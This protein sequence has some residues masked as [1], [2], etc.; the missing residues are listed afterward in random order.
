MV[1]FEDAVPSWL[2]AASTNVYAR[3]GESVFGE[4]MR[5]AL[6]I[7]KVVTDACSVLSVGFEVGRVEASG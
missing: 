5:L 3:L 2:V 6:L 1:M 4:R 7:S